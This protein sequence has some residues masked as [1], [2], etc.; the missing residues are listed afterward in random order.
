MNV[1]GRRR[2]IAGRISFDDT[3]GPELQNG[4]GV[5]TIRSGGGLRDRCDATIERD[6]YA[7][8]A[9][10]GKLLEAVA[11]RIVKDSALNHGRTRANLAIAE[12]YLYSRAQVDEDGHDIRCSRTVAGQIVFINGVETLGYKVKTVAV[13][14][15]RLGSS[16]HDSTALS[17]RGNHDAGNARLTG[18][19]NAV[20]IQIVEDKTVHR[21]DIRAIAV[22]EVH[23]LGLPRTDHDVD[24]IGR[25]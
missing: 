3:V 1:V 20:G 2:V 21:T 6:R 4:E 24:L 11:R 12:V 8:D 23:H 5:I 9:Q 18:I 14:A 17:G 25:G 13:L 19:L 7:R 22:A 10:L 16:A 15:L